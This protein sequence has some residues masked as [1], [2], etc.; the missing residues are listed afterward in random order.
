M[1]TKNRSIEKLKVK[2]W[3]KTCQA[4]SNQKKVNET[5]IAMIL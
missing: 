1:H 3:K 4:N 5:N 2:G